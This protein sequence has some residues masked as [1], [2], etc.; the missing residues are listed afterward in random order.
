MEHSHT[1]HLLQTTNS[2]M[3]TSIETNAMHDTNEEEKEAFY[4]EIKYE[5][6]ESLYMLIF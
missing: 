4:H 6:F 5:R 3:N 2:H 1:Y